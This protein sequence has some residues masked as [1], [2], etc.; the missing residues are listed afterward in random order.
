MAL[1]L[2]SIDLESN[3]DCGEDHS[4]LSTCSMSLNM[5]AA[6][7][8]K[9]LST[10]PSG[11]RAPFGSSGRTEKIGDEPFQARLLGGTSKGVTTTVKSGFGNQLASR[12]NTAPSSKVG[13]QSHGAGQQHMADG[14]M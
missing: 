14:A 5:F 7:L 6:S 12:N 1:H 11:S 2:Q 9:V 4:M 10:K 13:E 8:P 3:Y